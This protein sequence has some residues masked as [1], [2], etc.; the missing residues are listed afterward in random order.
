M[1]VTLYEDEG[2]Y[3]YFRTFSYDVQNLEDF[4]TP[5]PW[6]WSWDNETSA[7]YTTGYATVHEDADG[8]GDS[9]KLS[10]G[11]WDQDDLAA[12]GIDNDSISSFYV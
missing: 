5:F 8:N 11:F 10:P 3:G 6:P 7:L 2:G 1:S 4:Y 9:A 12:V